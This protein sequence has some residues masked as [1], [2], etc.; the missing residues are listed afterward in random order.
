MQPWLPS[1]R[2]GVCRDRGFGNAFLA[3]YDPDWTCDRGRRRTGPNC[4]AVQGPPECLLT[5]SGDGWRCERGFRESARGCV[6]LDVPEHAYLRRTRDSP[7][8]NRRLQAE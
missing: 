7:V 1:P 5:A 3:P 8:C 6:E 4:V 2:C